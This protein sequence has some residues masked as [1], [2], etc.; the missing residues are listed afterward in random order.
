MGNNKTENTKKQ[1]KREKIAAIPNKGKKQT[2]EKKLQ[3][4]S[5]LETLP[6]QMCDL[7]S[8]L[9]ASSQRNQ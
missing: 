4:L 1:G 9:R 8:T 3:Q 6:K 7:A 2:T 5:G